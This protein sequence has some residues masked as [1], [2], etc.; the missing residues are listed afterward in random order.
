MFCAYKIGL[1]TNKL[2]SI[3]PTGPAADLYYFR[4][5]VSNLLTL[6]ST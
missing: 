3:R 5:K 6:V 1:S 2:P 4:K